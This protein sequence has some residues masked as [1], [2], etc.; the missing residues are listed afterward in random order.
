MAI[1]PSN[2]PMPPFTFKQRLRLRLRELG[3]AIFDR[4]RADGEPTLEEAKQDAE[5]D[6]QHLVTLR[7][8]CRTQNDDLVAALEALE[9]TEDQIDELKKKLAAKKRPAKKKAT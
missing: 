7:R 6:A 9:R 5:H 8:L 2:D 1:S 4:F 3:A